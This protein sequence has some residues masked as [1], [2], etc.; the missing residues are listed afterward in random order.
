MTTPSRS[1]PVVLITGC[2][3]GFGRELSLVALERGFR[4]IST[5]RRVETLADLKEK[6]AET[7]KLDVTSPPQELAD[8]AKAA[9]AIYGQIDYL[10]N[11]AGYLLGGAM[12]ECTPEETMAQF[13]TNV[14]G[15]INTTNAFLPYFRTR[16]AGMV[17]N[18]SSQGGSLNMVGAGIYCATKAA[19]DSLSDTWARELAEFN[20]KCISIQ[21]GM[22]RTA[23]SAGNLRRG[24]H[25]IAE[26][27]AADK[28]I[29]E[30][31]A[32]TG[33]EKGDPTKAAVRILDFVT[34]EGRELPLRLA[35][36]DDAF[37]SV[38]AFHVQRL[39]DMEKFRSWSVGTNFD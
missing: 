23:V 14:F 26:Y 10:V 18:I 38:K 21:P 17:V 22:F 11:N 37:E 30:Y 6:G 13:N 34:A 19:V 36:G 12:E 5:A 32:A 3:T 33:T 16:R 28:V 4:V 20:V 9:W 1:G 31:N 27:T 29:T 15:L 24:T 8:F 25:R 7:L 35:L 39:A 2:S